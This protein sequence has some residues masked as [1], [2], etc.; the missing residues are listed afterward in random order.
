MN[1]H[2]NQPHDTWADHYDCAY[3]LTSR[4][5]YQQ[6]TLD[7]LNLIQ[8]FC[9]PPA[10]VVDYGAG[11]G[12]LAIP[13]A[14][15]GY[16]VTAVEACA[17]MCRVLKAK[18]AAG[19]EGAVAEPCAVCQQATVPQEQR[20]PV[21]VSVQNQDICQALD[22]S[23]FDLGLCVFTVPNYLVEEAQL[24][25]FAA[26]AAQA[27]KPDGKLLVSFVDDMQVL[28]SRYDRGPLSGES[29]HCKIQRRIEIT[30][31]RGRRY[32]YDEKTSGSKNGAGYNFTIHIPQRGWTKEEG[33][34]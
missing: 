25:R 30:T 8:K 24:R 32:D 1:H 6:L 18:A 19:V 22:E 13:L 33:V 15:L 5:Q 12:R 28:K 4:R 26:V 2:P 34:F 21:E 29:E 20:K 7:T 17:E 14:Q 23:G 31:V 27:I 16:R 3:K 11:T 10:R 9:P